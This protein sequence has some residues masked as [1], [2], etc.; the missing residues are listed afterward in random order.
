MCKRLFLY[1]CPKELKVLQNQ[2]EMKRQLKQSML[3]TNILQR[4]RKLG[5]V[6]IFLILSIVG[7]STLSAQDPY[8][9]TI[10]NINYVLYDA[11]LT[12]TVTGHVDGSNATGEL[13]IPESITYNEHNYSVTAIAHDAFFNCNGLTG[14]LIIPNTITSIGAEAFYGCHGFTGNLTLG[15]SLTTIDYIAFDGCSGF[16]GD[17]IIPNS[18]TDIGIG[19]F[20]GCSGFTGSLILSNSLIKISD[21]TFTECSGLTGNI[22]IPNSI[23]EIG[24]GAFA[25]CGNLTGSL[26]LPNNLTVLGRHAFS[27]CYGFTGSLTIPNSVIEIG[28][29]AFYNCNGFTGNLIISESVTK[30]EPFTF[31]GCSG[32]TGNLTIP[33]SVTEIGDGAFGYCSGFTGNLIIPNHVTAIGY[34]AF[35]E[36]SGLTGSLTIPDHVTTIGDDA[37]YNC[38]SFNGSLTIGNS[39]TTIGQ[40]AFSGFQYSGFTGNLII[41]NSVTTIGDAAF[42]FCYGFTGDLIIGKSVETIGGYAFS[43]CFGF[44]TVISLNAEPPTIDLECPSFAYGGSPTLIVCCG[45]KDSYTNSSWAQWDPGFSSIEEDCT[46]YSILIEENSLGSISTPVNSALMGEDIIISLTPITGYETDYIL[47]CKADNENQVVSIIPVSNSE[48]T[49]VMPNFDV[50]IKSHFSPISVDESNCI[51]THIYPNPTNGSVKIEAEALQHIRINNLLGQ[52][53][54][55]GNASGDMFEYNLGKHGTGIYLVIIETAN[56]TI[57]KKVSVVR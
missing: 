53:I 36:C 2:F 20:S 50:L 48:Y 30:I 12:A 56:G 40:G 8:G 54:Y 31:N 34:Q 41:P 4:N 22:N 15:N 19:A 39:V 47:V 33:S 29:W 27:G 28:E 26:I 18:V 11:T 21:N 57:A 3:Q 32:F 13:I 14:S 23:S 45:N 43:D 55:E 17:L 25:G 42:A 10:G 52:V 49:F 24:G 51:T 9:V 7:A 5:F 35:M 37:F 46:K 1:F 44:D 6:L 16:S 38:T